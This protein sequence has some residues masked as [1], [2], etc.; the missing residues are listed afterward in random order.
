MLL[1]LLALVVQAAVEHG[2]VFQLEQAHLVKDLLVAQVVQPLPEMV[3]VVVVVQ[4]RLEQIEVVV[5][6]VMVGQ[7]LHL[8]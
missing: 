8:L 6:V 5:L 3:V 1:V 2:Q 7:A 4:G